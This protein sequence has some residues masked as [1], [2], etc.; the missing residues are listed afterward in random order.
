MASG[1]GAT[2]G[3]KVS[4][5]NPCV[6]YDRMRMLIEAAG[7]ARQQAMREDP[8]AFKIGS[9]GTDTESEEEEVQD[10]EVANGKRPASEEAQEQPQDKR[11]RTGVTPPVTS[12]TP[13]F[14]FAEKWM[15]FQ[16][17]EATKHADL[18][19]KMVEMTYKLESLTERLQRSEAHGIEMETRFKDSEN[20]RLGME[21]RQR[22]IETS[23]AK[24]IEDFTQKLQD[25]ERLRIELERSLIGITTERLN[26]ARL[27]ERMRV[28]I[29]AEIINLN[30]KAAPASC[31]E[32]AEGQGV[33]EDSDIVMAEESQVQRRKHTKTLSPEESQ[34]IQDSIPGFFREY[35]TFDPDAYTPTRQTYDLFCLVH[36]IKASDEK[37]AKG[38]ISFFDREKHEVFKT[39]KGGLNVFAGIKRRAADDKQGSS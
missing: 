21:L 8:A 18:R 10:N 35:F 19:V 1:R 22:E 24:A 20:L 3:R 28:A 26:N 37:L 6:G 30:P 36:D 2:D 29:R 16:R 39:K 7:H 23:H 12:D 14:T 5:T 13:V 38:F 15:E 34:Q 33:E 9:N 27:K 11:A 25:S 32:T 17:E 31:M 4:P